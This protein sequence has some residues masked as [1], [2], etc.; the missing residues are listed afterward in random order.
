MKQSLDGLLLNAASHCKNGRGLDHA[1]ETLLANLREMKDR[2]EEGTAVIDEF[3]SVY[4]VKDS[5]KSL[6]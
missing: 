1:L 3:F 2:R 4:V 6:G 5:E